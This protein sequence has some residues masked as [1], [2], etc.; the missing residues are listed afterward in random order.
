[1]GGGVLKNLLRRA[2]D[3]IY[4]GIEGLANQPNGLGITTPHVW[5]KTK[6]RLGNMND[7]FV[8]PSMDTFLGR[9]NIKIVNTGG[10]GRTPMLQDMYE[11]LT[12]RK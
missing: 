9:D 2:D 12:R 1:M 7:M 11:L 4:K 8:D 5:E 10:L 6:Q 3:K